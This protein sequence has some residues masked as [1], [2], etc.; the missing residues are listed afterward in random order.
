MSETKHQYG[1][2]MNNKHLKL[3]GKLFSALLLCLSLVACNTTSDVT[4]TTINVADIT[5]NTKDTTITN[6]VLI[7]YDG[8]TPTIT[9]NIASGVEVSVTN[10]DVVVKSTNT[11]TPISYVI[12]G[13]ST[14]ASLKIY[15]DAAFNLVLNGTSLVNSDGPAINIQ[16]SKKA[17]VTLVGG[18]MNRLIDGANY[19]TSTEDQKGTFFSKG[20]LD[21][22]GAGSILIY[23]SYKHAIV[24]D[25]NINIQGGTISVT[26]AAADAIHAYSNFQMTGGNLTLVSTESGV[27]VEAG[28]VNISG[29]A[30]SITASSDGITTSYTGTDAS[31]SPYVQI[32]GGTLTVNAS[33]E[34]VKAINSNSYLKMNSSTATV[35]LY[36]SG[37]GCKGIKTSGDLTLTAGKLTI[38]TGGASY[39]NTTDKATVSS[40]GIS[41]GGN[42]AIQDG[43]ISISNTG[44]GGKG[45]IV[46]GA[47]TVA[48]GTITL[49]TSGATYT[50][51]TSETTDAKAFVGTGSIA[52][53]GGYLTI[54]SSNDAIKSAASVTVNGG[55]VDITTSVDGL[56]APKVTINAGYISVISTDDCIY[57]STTTDGTSN[58]GSLLS[59]TGGTVIVSSSGGECI[60]SNGSIAQSGGTVVV[61]GTTLSTTVA[62]D[63]NGTFNITG[64]VFIAGGPNNTSVAKATS[65]GSTQPTVFLKFTVGYAGG[66]P[67][68]LIDAGGNPLFTFIPTRAAY[69]FVYSSPTLKN[70]TTY[71]VFSGG[72]NGGTNIGGYYNGGTFNGGISRGSVTISGQLTTASL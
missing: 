68:S 72:E 12:S 17:T 33:G 56:S 41:C 1:E 9:N 11:S 24:S 71:N 36:T 45:I 22:T 20:Q 69:Y 25:G 13:Q 50:Y 31:I 6:A 2:I 47:S 65:A 8:T 62:F 67:F 57:T 5:T 35:A 32:N 60:D 34:K 4:D 21:I 29:G 19:A 26:Q 39:Y 14:N 55:S 53:N 40:S 28:Y 30:M 15:S 54:S 42:L 48:G 43:T 18:T 64:G 3:A 46:D 61:Q 58:D 16:S 63:Y 59:I 49:T 27:E 52:I 51:S 10:G 38:L 23:A 44:V 70:G 37:N 66:N 7:D